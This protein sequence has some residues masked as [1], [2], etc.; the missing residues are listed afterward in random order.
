MSS[1]FK[2]CLVCQSGMS[3]PLFFL[4]SSLLLSIFFFLS[5]L[6]LSL[7]HLFLFLSSISF[8]LSPHSVFVFPCLVSVSMFSLIHSVI[9]IS[10]FFSYLAY[11]CPLLI[12]NIS[13]SLYLSVTSLLLSFP[14]SHPFLPSLRLFITLFSRVGHL[15]FSKE[16][17]VL[18]ILLRSL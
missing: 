14:L 16:R 4:L 11:L 13:F 8:F 7:C 6:L 3:P 18:C 10:P 1:L 17:S 2:H 5:S 15:F 9:S 12:S